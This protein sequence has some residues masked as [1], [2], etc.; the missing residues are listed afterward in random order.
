MW[1]KV[2]FFYFAHHVYLTWKN[3]KINLLTVS[4]PQE[5]GNL[6][7]LVL[8]KEELVKLIERPLRNEDSQTLGMDLWPWQPLGGSTLLVLLLP[9]VFLVFSN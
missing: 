5:M 9:S 8:V 4:L 7:K 3:D 1:T 2:F 6:L